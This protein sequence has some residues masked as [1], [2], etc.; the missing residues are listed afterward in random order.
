MKGKLL[1]IPALALSLGALALSV[2]LTQNALPTHAATFLEGSETDEFGQG[3][4]AEKYDVVGDEGNKFNFVD[5]G[6]SVTF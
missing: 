4:S 5:K 3:I 6:G 1:L 2:P